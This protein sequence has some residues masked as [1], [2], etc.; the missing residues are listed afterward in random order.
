MFIRS[1]E[2][3]RINI[4]E[5]FQSI[6]CRSKPQHFFLTSHL[7]F[8]YSLRYV[9]ASG[10]GGMQ[11]TSNTHFSQ[12]QFENDKLIQSEY[13]ESESGR[14]LVYKEK[15]SGT[16]SSSRKQDSSFSS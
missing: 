2:K 9:V 13:L 12:L 7:L 16:E 5:T 4:R 14:H 3:Q 15:W 10:A 1:L 8:I 11:L 6:L